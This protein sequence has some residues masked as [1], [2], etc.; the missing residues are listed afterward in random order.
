MY[1]LLQS[2]LM[3]IAPNNDGEFVIAVTFTGG[4][5]PPDLEA[6]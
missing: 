2:Q 4:A 1:D 3:H 6:S 5:I